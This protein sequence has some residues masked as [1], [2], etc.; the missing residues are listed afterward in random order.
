MY[1]DLN[2]RSRAGNSRRPGRAGDGGPGGTIG[3][4]G[5]PGDAGA[6]A[7]A[8]GG[9]DM[10]PI[11]QAAMYLFIF[12]GVLFAPIMNFLAK[13]TALPKEVVSLPIIVGAAVIA[14]FIIP[15]IW[16]RVGAKQDA[17]LI[18]RLAVFF[19]NGVFWQALLGTIFAAAAGT[20]PTS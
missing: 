13:G 4:P 11:E 6:A 16:E 19:Q 9:A 12:L 10:P 17:P 5:G 20:T 2:E 8:T 1:F 3:V 14:F 7:D 18:V 15:A